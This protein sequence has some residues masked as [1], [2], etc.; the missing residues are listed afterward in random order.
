MEQNSAT[1]SQQLSMMP[2]DND[3]IYIDLGEIFF[4]LLG[5]WRSVL[6]AILIGAV[7]MGTIHVFLVK[8]SY[9]ADAQIFITNTD[10]VISI[11]DLQ[12]SSA[13]TEDYARIIKSRTVLKKVIG[14]LDLDIDFKA[15]QELVKVN[16]PTD[17]HIID[18]VVT[19][20]D[21]ELSRNIA[22]AL[23][24]VS[25]DQ[26]YQIV[27]SSEPTVIDYS[28]AD[29]VT[30]VSPSLFKYIAIGAMIGMLLMCAVIVFNVVSNTTIKTEED[31]MQ[32]LQMPVLAAVP[33]VGDNRL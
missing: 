12:L 27:G 17:T 26:I 13:L 30:D 14:E 31:A 22:N 16:N 7:L 18:I 32:Y 23:L 28:E 1:A 24:N 9:Q 3:E 33:Y 8:P 20:D 10:S 15:L 2:A 6:L 29:A 19:C 25:V 5:N 21:L 4:S 11:S